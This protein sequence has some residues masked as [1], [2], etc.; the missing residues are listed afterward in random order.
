M[1]RQKIITQISEQWVFWR[2]STPK[3]KDFRL[4]FMKMIQDIGNK[5][6]AKIDNLQET[7]SKKI[8][9]LRIMQIKM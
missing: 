2:L 7:L 6:E 1:K 8:K 5:L 4:M 9:D 3:E